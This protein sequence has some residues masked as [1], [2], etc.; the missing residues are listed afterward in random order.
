[1]GGR[2]RH[3]TSPVEPLRWRIVERNNR[4]SVVVM[5]MAPPLAP[6]ETL[7]WEGAASYIAEAYRLARNSG[8]PIYLTK[9]GFKLKRTKCGLNETPD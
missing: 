3:D 4:L 6:G 8:L 5:D 2:K 7:V 9:D 1:M